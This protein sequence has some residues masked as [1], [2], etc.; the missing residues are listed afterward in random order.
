M[1]RELLHT[2]AQKVDTH[3]KCPGFLKQVSAPLQTKKGY[4]KKWMPEVI[5]KFLA[6][7]VGFVDAKIQ[8]CKLFEDDPDAQRMAHRSADTWA[9]LKLFKLSLAGLAHLRS[10]PVMSVQ[11]SSDA[12]RVCRRNT[13]QNHYS[14]GRLVEAGHI[15]SFWTSPHN[16]GNVC[17]F[18]G[19]WLGNYNSLH[20]SHRHVA[21]LLVTG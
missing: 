3:L 20:H 6:R 4:T 5:G 1:Q 18:V 9:G 21:Y 11:W 14:F 13:M 10:A 15:V 7:N 8:S 2:L 19:N 12:S 16:S 17:R